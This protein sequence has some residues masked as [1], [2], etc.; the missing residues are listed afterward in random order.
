MTVIF[1]FII[2]NIPVSAIVI[3]ENEK[4]NKIFMFA[5]HKK[6]LWWWVSSV[7]HMASPVIIIQVAL[8][9]YSFLKTHRIKQLF[10]TVFYFLTLFFT[11]TRANVL[12]A[13]LVI[14]LI[15]LYNLY[16][17]RKK[18]YKTAFLIFIFVAFALIAVF[19]MLTVKNSSSDMK[20][21]HMVSYDILFSENPSYLLFGQGAG[22]WLY[23][24]GWKKLCTNT[25]ISYMELIRMFGLLF[26]VPI[27][28]LYAYPFLH[29]VRKPCFYSFSV[30][31]SYLA[32]LFIAGTNPLL[33]GPT[34]FIVFWYAKYLLEKGEP[35][36]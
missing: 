31:I 1:S 10:F 19:L 28:C 36:A 3:I 13:I 21:A 18:L 29:F 26:T 9:F 4:L 7:F 11:G 15:Y 6:F 8:K 30:S 12:A 16:F 17:E 35:H 32:Y 2:L 5:E 20:D 33:I 34:G 24:V 23:D 27:I 25:E 22:S 14:G